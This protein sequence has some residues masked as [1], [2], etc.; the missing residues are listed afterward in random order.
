M[1][2]AAE[3]SKLDEYVDD[4]TSEIPSIVSLACMHLG[5]FLLSRKLFMDKSTHYDDATACWD[6]SMLE[7]LR[8]QIIL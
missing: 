8:Y 3:L 2:A 1:A 7:W 4:D 5:G 6:M